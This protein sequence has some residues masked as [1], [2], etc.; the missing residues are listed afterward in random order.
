MAK[1]HT[2]EIKFILDNPQMTTAQMAEHL[3]RTA[4]SVTAKRHALT[5]RYGAKPSDIEDMEQYEPN[6]VEYQLRSSHLCATC[7]RTGVREHL[8]NSPLPLEL[9]PCEFILSTGITPPPRAE[10]TERIVKDQ[11]HEPEAVKCIIK[12]PFYINR[13]NGI[14]PKGE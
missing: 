12:C 1:W 10:Y 9:L 14:Y 3:G 11:K 4:T 2:N 5:G 13:K 6:N 8:M 7:D